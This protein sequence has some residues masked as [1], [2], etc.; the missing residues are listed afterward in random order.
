MHSC[1]L[2][3]P[4]LRIYASKMKGG[5]HPRPVPPETHP[6]LLIKPILFL[7][8]SRL[9][10]KKRGIE[11]KNN[12]PLCQLWRLNSVC[13]PNHLYHL[14]IGL[15]TSLPNS[16]LGHSKP[17]Q[18]VC[19]S[20]R[21]NHHNFGSKSVDPNSKQSENVP[22]GPGSQIGVWKHYKIPIQIAIHDDLWWFMMIYDDLCLWLCLNIG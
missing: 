17:T 22:I 1:D 9:A 8:H 13:D 14:S 16:I 19:E 11:K 10:F 5:P 12:P 21:Q 20:F 15:L 4:L 7:G 18:T 6:V 2:C 3:S